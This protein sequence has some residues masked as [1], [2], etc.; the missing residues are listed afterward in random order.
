MSNCKLLLII[1]FKFLCLSP[2]HST[3]REGVGGGG[4][5]LLW[6][7]K[8]LKKVLPD[9]QEKRGFDPDLGRREGRKQVRFKAKPGEV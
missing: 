9:T 6:V 7:R 8:L 4:G 3:S 1:H 2:K 5:Y